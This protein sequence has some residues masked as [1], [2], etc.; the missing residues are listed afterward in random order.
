MGLG[1]GTDGRWHRVWR[2]YFW[3]FWLASQRLVGR[4][5]AV[6]GGQAALRR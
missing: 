3:P 4:G 2:L 5:G 1:D 6:A